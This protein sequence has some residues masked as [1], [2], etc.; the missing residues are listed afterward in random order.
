VTIAAMLFKEMK[1]TLT[2]A[3]GVDSA[4][5][6]FGGGTGAQSSSGITAQSRPARTFDV[7]VDVRRRWMRSRQR[8]LPRRV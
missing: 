6:A 1:L 7:V 8:Q 3:I 4:S 5:L 2:V